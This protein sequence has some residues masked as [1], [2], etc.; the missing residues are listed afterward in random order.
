MSSEPTEITVLVLVDALRHDYLTEEDAPFL[1]E[2]ARGGLYGSLIPTFGFDPDAAHFAGLFPDEGESGAHY[3]FDPAHSPFGFTKFFPALLDTLPEWPQRVGHKLIQWMVQRTSKNMVL[4]N[5][6]STALVPFR[7]LHYFD[8]SQ[9]RL[10]FEAGFAPRQT[11]FDLLEEAGKGWFFHANPLHRVNSAAVLARVKDEVK[12]PCAFAYLLIGDLD[13][14]GHDF[15]PASAERK[16]VLRQV[17][18]CLR[19]IHREVSKRFEVVNWILFGDH[20]MV[21]VKSITDVWGALFGA[22]LKIGKDYVFFLDSTMARFW[23]FNEVAKAQVTSALASVKGGRLLTQEDLDHY[24]LNF[25]H[26]RFGDL[27]FL[28]DPGVLIS[29]NFFQGKRMVKG[30]HGYAPEFPDHQAAVIINSPHV[31]PSGRLAAPVDMRQLFPTV[32]KFLGLNLPATCR[33]ESIV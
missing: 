24:H 9:K 17:D 23:F 31:P 26:N 18:A 1:Y 30:M 2:L 3:W 8:F 12:P 15:G 28:A 27:F 22:K 20:G 29:P 16:A 32:L 19:E 10:P 11:I 14:A 7:F 25:S 33:L 6:A 21:E 13:H 4:H 5:Q